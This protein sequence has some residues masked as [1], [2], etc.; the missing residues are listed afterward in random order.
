[1]EN[2]ELN[3]DIKRLAKKL[4]KATNLVKNNSSRDNYYYLIDAEI[5]TEFLRL[6]HADKK[7]EIMNKKSIQIML[8]INQ[9]WSFIP[10]HRLF[11]MIELKDLV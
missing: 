11:L 10:H 5:K 9:I 3:R 8:R 4:I 2:S 7:A 1:M 6:Y